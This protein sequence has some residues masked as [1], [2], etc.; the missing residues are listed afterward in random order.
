MMLKNY[1]IHNKIDMVI[2]NY[3]QAVAPNLLNKEMQTLI[4]F[5]MAWVSAHYMS[6]H[7]YSY[8]CTNNS[9]YGFLISPFVAAAPHCVALRWIIYEGGN[10][11]TSMW[12]SLGTYM[13][14]KLLIYNS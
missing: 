11:I 4:I 6:T 9:F 1:L 10:T 7:I 2:T 5:Y 3:V 8:F 14:A 13:G 12:L